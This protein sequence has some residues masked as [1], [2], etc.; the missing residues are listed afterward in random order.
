MEG[1]PYLDGTRHRLREALDY[2][3][4]KAGWREHVYGTAGIPAYVVGYPSPTIFVDGD[5]IGGLGDER[6]KVYKGVRLR[7]VT[8]FGTLVQALQRAVA[9]AKP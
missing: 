2:V 8:P 3:G 1:C 4:Q 5:A 7:P 9:G 6:A